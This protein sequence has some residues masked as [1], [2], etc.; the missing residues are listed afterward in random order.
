VRIQRTLSATAD[1]HQLVRRLYVAGILVRPAL[2]DSGLTQVPGCR[3]GLSL[4][5][6]AIDRLQLDVTYLQVSTLQFG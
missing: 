5:L 2:L 6:F 3:L 4:G 1:V